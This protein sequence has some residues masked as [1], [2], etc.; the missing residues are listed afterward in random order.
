MLHV[1]DV[2][3]RD[4]SAE[5]FEGFCFCA[6][7]VASHVDIEAKR[8][9]N[10]ST[11]SKAFSNVGVTVGLGSFRKQN[12]YPNVFFGCLLG[13]DFHKKQFQGATLGDRN[14]SLE[15]NGIRARLHISVGRAMSSTGAI[16]FGAGIAHRTVAVV[17]PQENLRSS[18]LA[19]SFVAGFLL[20]PC[21]KLGGG[22]EVEYV[23]GSRSENKYY[24][25]SCGSHCN[26]RVF[27]IYYIRR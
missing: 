18:K 14:V 24:K 20:S 21:K 4:Y 7:G 2:S 26:L 22:L 3:C 5:N 8:K 19:P 13:V 1:A 12:A 17:N 11:V 10:D 27:G 15:A 16:Y 6:G 25:L 9:E 23:L